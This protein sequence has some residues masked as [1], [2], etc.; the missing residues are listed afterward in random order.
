MSKLTDNEINAIL[1]GCEGVTPGPWLADSEKSDGCYGSGE[2]CHE[3]YYTSTLCDAK[4]RRIADALNCDVGEL[5]EESSEDDHYA[6]DEQSG[7]NF[8]HLS[9][10]D[11]D[12]IRSAFTELLEL[13]EKGAA[14]QASAGDTEKQLRIKAQMIHMGEKI[15]WGSDSDIM[16]KAAD[17]LAAKDAEIERLKRE[18]DHETRRAMI[19]EERERHR[20]RAVYLVD[21]LATIRAIQD[22]DVGDPVPPIA[23]IRPQRLADLLDQ[24][25]ALTAR[26]A[27]LEGA[28]S[29]QS[30]VAPWMQVCFGTEVSADRVERR[31]RFI[32]EALELLQAVDGTKSEALQLVDYVFGREKGEQHQEVGGV[33]ITLAALCLASGLDMHKAGE[34]ELAR[35]WTKVDAIRA[36]QAAKPKHSVLPVARAALEPKP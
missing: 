19:A 21:P 14:R 3:G 34:D 18:L 36:K 12:T 9:R 6:W 16:E 25:T 5:H 30:R 1:A 28:L 27:E 10:C 23:E 13:R 20:E 11:P 22:T 26:V 17:A 2:D 32:E 24:V 7:L 33:M 35:I 8:A 4:G 15:A 31:H 29:L